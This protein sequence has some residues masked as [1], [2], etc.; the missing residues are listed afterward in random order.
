MYVDI[1][2]KMPLEYFGL[3]KEDLID[4]FSD[5]CWCWNNL[6]NIFEKYSNDRRCICDCVS[7]KLIE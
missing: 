2:I 6:I 4:L 5:E 3:N 1:N 7:W